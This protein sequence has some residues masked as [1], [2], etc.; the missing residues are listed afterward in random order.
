[1]NTVQLDLRQFLINYCYTACTFIKYSKMFFDGDSDADF[2]EYDNQSI[3]GSN[4][5]KTVKV[6]DGSI[7]LFIC[8]QV[9]RS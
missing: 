2:I 7:I 8:Y 6:G 4:N 3:V 9:L 5:T 1:M